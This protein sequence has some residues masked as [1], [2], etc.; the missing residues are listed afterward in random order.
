MLS[1]DEALPVLESNLLRGR[2][3]IAEPDVGVAWNVF[4][5]FAGEPV[6]VSTDVLVFERTVRPDKD[7][8]PRLVWSLKRQFTRPDDGGHE[9]LHLTFFFA[10]RPGDEEST[11]L[12]CSSDHSSTEA[13]LEHLEALPSFRDGLERERPVSLEMTQEEVVGGVAR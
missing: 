4:R 8:V 5:A 1:V 9:Q 7:D 13:F 3:N 12:E 6:D 10:L 11:A 2:F